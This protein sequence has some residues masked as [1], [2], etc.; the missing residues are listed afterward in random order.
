MIRDLLKG[1]APNICSH[2]FHLNGIDNIID[3]SIEQISIGIQMYRMMSV[4]H[5]IQVGDIHRKNGTDIMYQVVSVV[6]CQR[7]DKD[8]KLQPS[9]NVFLKRI[10]GNSS[11]PMKITLEDFMSNFV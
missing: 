6:K 5:N 10:T 2:V 3:K 1:I 7:V 9:K 8:G 4:P 11:V